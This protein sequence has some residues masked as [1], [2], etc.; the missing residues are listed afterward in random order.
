MMALFIAVVVIGAIIEHDA[1]WLPPV[2]LLAA[3]MLRALW[4]STRVKEKQASEEDYSA[5]AKS[6]AER[7]DHRSITVA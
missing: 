7:V 1:W 6:L 2:L 4:M 5:G 3:F